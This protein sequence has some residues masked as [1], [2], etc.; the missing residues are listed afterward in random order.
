MTK[1]DRT[2]I[3][4]CRAEGITIGTQA[5]MVLALLRINTL[6]SLQKVTE[7]T[8]V[9]VKR[10]PPAVPPWPP[11]KPAV[12]SPDRI[13]KLKKR[14]PCVESTDAHRRFAV[15]REGMTVEAAMTRGVTTR[16]L[17]VWKSRGYLEVSK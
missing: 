9:E 13:R 12:A 10:C 16:D 11:T 1:P 8:G 15:L 3:E 7:L 4:Y 5:D 14:N 6:E 17:R 2:I